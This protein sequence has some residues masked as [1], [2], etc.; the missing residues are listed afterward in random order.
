MRRLWQ[1]GQQ[2]E[3]AQRGWRGRLNF[4]YMIHYEADF[5]FDVTIFK[6]LKNRTGECDVSP[7]QACNMLT[8]CIEHGDRILL[9]TD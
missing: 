5:I 9:L 3:I 6:I 2:I 1:N 7:E 4:G 8:D